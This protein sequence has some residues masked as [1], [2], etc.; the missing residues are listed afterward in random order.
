LTLGGGA[1]GMTSRAALG[2]RIWEARS[3]AISPDVWLGG[4]V[5]AGSPLGTRRLDEG[6]MLRGPAGSRCREIG[7]SVTVAKASECVTDNQ[8]QI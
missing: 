1:R 4:I 7:K 8:G 2:Y 3:E 5:N 6:R